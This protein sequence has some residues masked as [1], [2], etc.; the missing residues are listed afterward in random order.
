MSTWCLFVF[1]YDIPYIIYGI[2]Y[3]QNKCLIAPVSYTK[4]KYSALFPYT[5]H[6][7]PFFPAFILV[8]LLA[9]DQ[10]PFNVHLPSRPT[11]GCIWL[12]AAGLQRCIPPTQPQASIP[13]PVATS[14]LVVAAFHRV[15]TACPS[16]RRCHS[17][18]RCRAATRL[19]FT[20]QGPQVNELPAA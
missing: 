12:F 4:M 8:Q 11:S 6:S 5:S 3:T 1:I 20:R 17:W 2:W 16:R 10:R 9:L 15:D 7:L 14:Q 19:G 13:D 18:V